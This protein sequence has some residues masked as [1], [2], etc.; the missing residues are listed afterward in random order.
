MSNYNYGTK[1]YYEEKVERAKLEL[2]LF[3]EA[4]AARIN[5]EVNKNQIASEFIKSIQP[6]QEI[7]ESAKNSIKYA[8]EELAKLDAKKDE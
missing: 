5:V 4:I 1:E 2:D 7:L 3:E 8:E 6:Y